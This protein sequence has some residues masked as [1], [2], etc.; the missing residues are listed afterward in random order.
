MFNANVLVAG[1][2]ACRNVN[3]RV[4]GQRTDISAMRMVSD[5][6][7]YLDD[8]VQIE[9]VYEARVYAGKVKVEV[10]AEVCGSSKYSKKKS[11]IGKNDPS[12][13]IVEE[14]ERSRRGYSSG[15]RYIGRHH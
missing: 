12:I 5:R 11:I 9:G 2:G 4:N 14:L 1:A 7:D 10:F 6:M 15:Y 8:S 13:L 3:I